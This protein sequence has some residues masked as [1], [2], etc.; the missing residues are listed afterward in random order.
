MSN[1][2]TN[3]DKI[4]LAVEIA[5]LRTELHTSVIKQLT[6][7]SKALNILDTKVDVLTE[8]LAAVETKVEERTSMKRSNTAI[9][10]AIISG[11][12]GLASVILTVMG[13]G[14]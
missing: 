14:M 12:F 10:V 13:A 3:G 6:D 9:T 4:K 8:R 1:E 5:T 7:V 11:V 2:A